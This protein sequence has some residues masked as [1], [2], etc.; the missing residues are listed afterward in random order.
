MQLTETTATHE[1]KCNCNINETHKLASMFVDVSFS[2]I[3][4]LSIFRA[5]TLASSSAMLCNITE[6]T[7]YSSTL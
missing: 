4:C 1:L 7:S 6:I 3:T 2:S 5:S